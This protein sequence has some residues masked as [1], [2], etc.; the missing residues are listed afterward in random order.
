MGRHLQGMAW[1]NSCFDMI[2]P[3]ICREYRKQSIRIKEHS[4]CSSLGWP[5]GCHLLSQYPRFFIK[6]SKIMAFL[7]EFTTQVSCEGKLNDACPE[8]DNTAG[9]LLVLLLTPHI[10]TWQLSF[11]DQFVNKG[12][13]TSQKERGNGSSESLGIDLT[14][15]SPHGSCYSEWRWI[16]M[17]LYIRPW[18]FAIN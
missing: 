1:F 13:L 7:S 10:P 3:A 5:W 9:R 2:S 14:L 18:P 4:M 8:K 15:I 16:A 17:A 11:T 12:W 6:S